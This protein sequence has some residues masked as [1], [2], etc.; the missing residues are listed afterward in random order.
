MGVAPLHLPKDRPHMQVLQ[1]HH[2]LL[3]PGRPCLT[4]NTQRNL[5][6]SSLHFPS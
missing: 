2:T 1:L 5:R 6:A 3:E 4:P